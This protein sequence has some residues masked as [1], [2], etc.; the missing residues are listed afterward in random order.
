MRPHRGATKGPAASVAHE[1]TQGNHAR[2]SCRHNAFLRRHPHVSHCCLSLIPVVRHTVAPMAAV[3]AHTPV[4]PAAPCTAKRLSASAPIFPP[5]PPSSFA[6]SL[7][8]LPSTICAVQVP[9]YPPLPPTAQP[10]LPPCS[11]SAPTTRGAGLVQPPLP[12]YPPAM[13]VFQP[14][15]PPQPACQSLPV[16]APALVTPVALPTMAPHPLLCGLSIADMKQYEKMRRD[17]RKAT[18]KAKKPTAKTSRLTKPV[19]E[20]FDA[21]FLPFGPAAVVVPVV[22]PPLP[23]SPPLPPMKA[24]AASSPDCITRP[25]SPVSAD[26]PESPPTLSC[27]EAALPSS[28]PVHQMT[29]DVAE[30]V[31]TLGKFTTP[32]GQAVVL[33]S[34]ARNV[35]G[36]CV[37]C[38]V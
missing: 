13:P 22:Q 14:P 12:T 11:K 38:D 7:H 1:W 26:Q 24:A 23:P 19:V 17:V 15:L 34:T 8:A 18:A 32:T 16:G 20:A 33:L 6:T 35:P 31:P 37:K 5:L 28:S 36:A 21:V 9:V 30:F 2:G 25:M 3:T 27:C 10:P 29:Q 4:Q